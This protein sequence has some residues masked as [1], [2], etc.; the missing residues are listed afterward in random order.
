MTCGTPADSPGCAAHAKSLPTN[1]RWA[2]SNPDSSAARR[3][4]MTR[5]LAWSTSFER[6]LEHGSTRV[7]RSPCSPAISAHDLEMAHHARF[8]MLENV[9]VVHPFAGPVVRQPCDPRATLW[10]HIHGVL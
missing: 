5:R 2:I 10:R 6:C 7:I 4:S 9:A 8:V 3:R 1:V